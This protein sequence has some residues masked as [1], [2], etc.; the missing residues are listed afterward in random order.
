MSLFVSPTKSPAPKTKNITAISL[1]FVGLLL[2]MVVAQLF[3]FEEFAPA[4]STLELPGGEPLSSVL[5]ALIVTGEVIALP[6][7]L[8][9]RLSPAFR[10]V[11]MVASWVVVTFWLAITVWEA[12]YAHASSSTLLGSAV[13]LPVG[14]WNVCI[15][16]SLGILAAWS[17]WGM[18]PLTTKTK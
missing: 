11:S 8:R 12:T 13:P 1:L 3:A 10:V 14:W 5:A 9:M 6:F 17:S 4:L 2:L 16:V 7:L 15:V 18:W